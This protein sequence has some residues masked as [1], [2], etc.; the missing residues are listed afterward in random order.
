MERRT[1]KG[2]SARTPS[3]CDL[4]EWSAVRRPAGFVLHG[5]DHWRVN[6][7]T[8][9]DP[10]P[11]L[12]AQSENFFRGLL[13][14]WHEKSVGGGVESGEQGLQSSET[15]QV[16]CRRS[17]LKCPPVDDCLSFEH[18]E[19]FAFADGHVV[20]AREQKAEVRAG[21]QPTTCGWRKM[22]GAKSANAGTHPDAEQPPWAGTVEELPKW[23]VG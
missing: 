21:Q 12:D 8:S 18:D 16:G 14:H 19:P 20:A 5:R 10:H 15:G 3:A 11:L 6:N 17:D 13:P 2:A 22:T 23:K 9:D 4:F 1:L 7:L